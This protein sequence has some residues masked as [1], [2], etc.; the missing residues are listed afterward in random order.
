MKELCKYGL[1]LF[2]ICV[3]S[4]GAL[5]LINKITKPVIEARA[6]ENLKSS[7][8]EIIP[9]ALR[10][11][12]MGPGSETIYYKAYGKDNEFLGAAFVVQAKGYSSVIE[13]LA[14]I[15][16]DGTI[17]A[18]KILSQNETPGLGSRVTQESFTAQFADKNA[19]AFEG[20]EAITGAT[21]SSGAVIQAVK[22]K[23]QEV[24]ALLKANEK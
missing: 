16:R 12:T 22:Q 15:R 4:A 17:I 8:K 24:L 14:G 6:E 23:S 5:A 21:I 19:A 1:I 3:T 13:T 10:F 11:E 7:L 2:L 20:V 18:V 9:E